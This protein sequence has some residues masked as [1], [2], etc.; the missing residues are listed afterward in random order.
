VVAIA[1]GEHCLSVRGP[2]DPGLVSS[3]LSIPIFGWWI[4]QGRRRAN[5]QCFGFQVLG[6]VCHPRSASRES[7]MSILRV[8]IIIV[9]VIQAG[10]TKLAD[11]AE[12]LDLL[13]LQFC[14]W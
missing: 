13:R 4:A 14:N 10:Q 7:R 6:E 8:L 3:A 9:R 12:T 5:Q 1:A 11:I 2:P